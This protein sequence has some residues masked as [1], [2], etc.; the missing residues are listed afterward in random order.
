M[1][2]IGQGLPSNAFTG[3]DTETFTGDGTANK[4]FTLAKQPFSENSILV[5]IDG[6]VQEAT[7]D[8]TVSGTT[9]TLVGTA[10]NNSEVNVVHLGAALALGEASKLDTNGASD[11][12]ILDQ[13]GDSTISAD[14]D[15]QI[16][17]KTGGTD[18]MHIASDG[19]VLISKTSNAYQTT[20]HEFLDGGRAFH[21]ADGGK[22]LSLV[23]NSSNGAIMDFYNSGGSEVGSIETAAS[24]IGI[25]LGGTA[26]ANLLDDYE[27]GTWTGTFKSTAGTMTMNSSYQTGRYVKV[28]R[29][30]HVTGY[31]IATGNGA[32]NTSQSLM[33]SGLPFNVASSS[34]TNAS[35]GGQ[36]LGYYT[37]LNL[38]SGGVPV[39]YVRPSEDAVSF[40]QSGI[41][42]VDISNFTVANLSTDGS[43]ML[44]VSYYTDS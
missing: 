3:Y 23:R 1:P 5:T 41:G 18:R 21:T 31:F 15:D 6:V 25:K 38:D 40:K 22:A 35:Y 7:E 16:D 9:L 27:E 19:D 10:P 36:A 28:G 44:S 14:T 37:G 39:F 8:F 26:S 33:M 11:Q 17:F 4:T 2:Y 20:G 32:A 13:D 24:G 43:I 34:P 29:L 30:V 12:L 42:T